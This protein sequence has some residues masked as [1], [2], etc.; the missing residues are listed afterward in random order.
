MPYVESFLPKVEIST[1]NSVFILSG[2]GYG[3][4]VFGNEGTQWVPLFYDLGI[5]VFVVKNS[6]PKGDKKRTLNDV[7]TTMEILK[8]Q[9]LE[10]KVNWDDAGA[11]ESSVMGISRHRWQRLLMKRSIRHFRFY[12]I[13]LSR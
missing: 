3:M 11:M 10:L 13:P 2:G 8:A 9:A 5:S 7:E 12:F 1:G 6:L 4:V